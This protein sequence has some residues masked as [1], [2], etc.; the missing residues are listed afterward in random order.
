MSSIPGEL[1]RSLN[2]KTKMTL[3]VSAVVILSLS[4]AGYLA[5]SYFE[6]HLRAAI[7]RNQFLLA[8]AVANEIDTKLLMAHQQLIFA[9]REVPTAALRS[10]EVAQRFLDSKGYLSS[11][12]DNHYT[13]FSAAGISI[14]EAPFTPNRRGKDYS[15]RPYFKK[16]VETQKPVIS[17]PYLSSQAHTHPAIMMTAPIFNSKGALAG[18]LVGSMDLMGDNILGDIAKIRVGKNGFLS[19]TTADRIMVMHPDKT[20]IMQPIP[21]GNKLYDAALE[22]F[23]GTDDTVTTSGIPMVTSV[24]R[25]KVNG[26]IVVANLPQAEAYAAI[27]EMKVYLLAAGAGIVTIVSVIISFLIRRSTG[28]L[29]LLTR[30]VRELSRKEGAH[31]LVRIETD[32]EIGT[33]ARAFNTMVAELDQQHAALRESEELFRTLAEQSLAGI[34][35]IQD[36]LFRYV[37]PR[38]AEIFKYSAGEV[39]DKLGPGDLVH[40]GDW[41]DAQGHYFFRAATK[42]QDHIDVE[43]YG[44]ATVHRSRPAIIGTIV[45]ITERTMIEER[46]KRLALYDE[47]TGLP[48]RSLFFDRLHQL[49]ALAKRNQYALAILF[50]DLDRFK[51]VNDTLGHEMGDLLLKEVSRR[52]TSCT[53]S[54]DT[55]ARVGGDEFIGI[56]GKIAAPDDAL[57]VARKITD[58]LSKPFLLRDH[59]CSIGASIGI[60]LH[61]E[62]GSDAETLVKKAD[63]AMYRVK[64]GG[65]G[66]SLLY[67]DM[68]KAAQS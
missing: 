36:G 41:P 16:T 56:C 57:I 50:I 61:P 60:S 55:V 32:D 11:F 17:D 20:R 49:L 38:F 34:Y 68:I 5:T 31:K 47:L 30:H 33:L 14:A 1:L 63:D 18:F 35:L 15:F 37:N 26:W 48:N 25:M 21:A 62:D 53:R 54:A 45:D 23:E 52:L 29:L 2:L 66:G 19:L 7:D 24:K 46:L 10:P 65:K 8:S 13:L 4:L 39:T 59:E 22:G 9:A 42:T 40:S 51:A 27:N 6:R 28:P 64:E 44:S 3:G 12:F 43:V 67:R 58:A